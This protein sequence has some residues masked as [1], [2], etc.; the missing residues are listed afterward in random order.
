MKEII[1]KYWL[2]IVILLVAVIGL[3]A[4]FVG[5][6]KANT[7]N[8]QPTPTVQELPTQAPTAPPAAA[9]GYGPNPPGSANQIDQQKQQLEQNQKDYPLAALL[10][11]RTDLFTV[12]HY[13]SPLKLVVIVKKVED[14]KEAQM[15]IEN[16]LVKN[17]LAPDS[18]QIIW[19]IGG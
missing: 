17:R 2:V 4:L 11:Y 3:V 6:P 10:P 13:R 19:S 7:Q 12:D 15:E 8:Q 9:K 18:H 1:K 5:G 14:E 16:W